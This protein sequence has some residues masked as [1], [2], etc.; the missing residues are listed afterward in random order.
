M[1]AKDIKALER[2]I[3]SYEVDQNLST[4]QRAAA[5]LA[6]A[7]KEAPYLP[8]DLTLLVRKALMLTRTPAS[9][10]NE[11]KQFR[12]SKMFQVRQALQKY[13]TLG[14][15]VCTGYGYRATADWDDFFQHEVVRR[16]RRAGKGAQHLQGVMDIVPT[17]KLSPE[18]QKQFAAYK[19]VTRLLL[20]ND[21]AGSLL[22]E[23]A[24]SDGDKTKK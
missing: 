13:H 16:A 6:F 21:V 9:N 1:S 10:T 18:N 4:G 22:T 11:V 12:S 17:S 15:V 5:V 8:V 2:A 24:G 14:M 7:A 20:Q 3:L 23:N 19:K